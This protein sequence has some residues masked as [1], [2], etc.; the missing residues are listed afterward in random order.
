MQSIPSQYVSP[1]STYFTEVALGNVPGVTAHALIGTSSTIPSGS[2]E[3][4]WHDASNWIPL[5]TP[6]FL[7]VRSGGHIEDVP[8][9]LGTHQIICSCLDANFMPVDILV[10]TD[11]SNGID[12][13]TGLPVQ[14]KRI[15]NAIGF[16]GGT[17][18]GQNL[19]DIYLEGD[20]SGTL[21]CVLPAGTNRCFMGLATV[22][23]NRKL[24]AY[25]FEVLVS[26]TKAIETRLFASPPPT[27]APP[28]TS[29][30]A[31]FTTPFITGSLNRLN[32]SGS[33]SI[34]GPLDLEVQS[35]LDTGSGGRVAV[36]FQWTEHEI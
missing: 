32:Y 9:G 17:A 19:G 3:T 6:E 11:G 20:A 22:P 12:I 31:V 8:G 28:Y 24:V 16:S 18:R 2:Y 1:S 26:S 29:R 34:D 7:R 36:S 5:I 25:S 15:N 33:S 14:M 13:T 4:V 10:S 21:M 23:A 30:F 35:Q 27:A